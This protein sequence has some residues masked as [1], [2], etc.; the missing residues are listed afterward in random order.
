[1]HKTSTVNTF[2]GV[3][4]EVKQSIHAT[5][6]T[7]Q[8]VIEVQRASNQ[9]M[10]RGSH[11]MASNSQAVSFAPQIV[12]KNFEVIIE[13]PVVREIIVE[14]PYEVIVERPYE[15]RIEK[16]VVYERYVDRPVERIIEN[17]VERVI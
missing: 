15:N 3:T 5:H 14:K 12:E 2:Q 9:P 6:T 1:M 7:S 11:M 8:N 10:A 16:E 17:E 13:K 4:Q